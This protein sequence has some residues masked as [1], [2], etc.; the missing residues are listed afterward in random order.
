MGCVEENVDFRGNDL[1]SREDVPSAEACA[2]ICAEEDECFAWTWSKSV[3]RRAYR[4]QI[5]NGTRRTT[6]SWKFAPT[7]CALKAANYGESVFVSRNKISG[8]KNCGMYLKSF[9]DCRIE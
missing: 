3:R 7:L 9:Q 2:Q 6:Y 4:Q 1:K 8:R 5:V